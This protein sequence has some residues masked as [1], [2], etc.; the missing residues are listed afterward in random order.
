MM[1]EILTAITLCSN[2]FFFGFGFSFWVWSLFFSSLIVISFIDLNFQLIPD[3]FT[4]S[5]IVIGLGLNFF[6]PQ[7]L[8]L[9]REGN[10]FL[11]SL[12]G[13]LVGG[14]SIYLLGLVGLI[15]FKRESMGFG[16]VKLMAMIGAFLGLKLVLLCF[17]VAPI[18]GSVWGLILKIKYKKDII[19]Y[20]PFLSL[21]SLISLYWG[22]DILEYFFY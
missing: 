19:P 15:L 6:Y 21:G 4:I 20:G 18:L 22:R 10:A 9:A 14:G 7:V 17:F 13:T 2:F 5:G 16:D 8:S 3:I 1:V 12:F 11:D